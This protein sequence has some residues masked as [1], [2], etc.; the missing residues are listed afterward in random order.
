[1]DGFDRRHRDRLKILGA[2]VIYSL[3]NG[4]FAIKPLL[5]LTR[6]SAR[7]EVE[8]SIQNKDFIKLEIMVKGKEKIHVKGNVIRLSDP[9][10]EDSSYIVVQFL[11][12]GT[13]ERYNSMESYDLLGELIEENLIPA[14]AS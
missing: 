11:P 4:Q 13:D 12:F 2:E 9:V 8:H 6:N 7:F 5:D 3:K 1:M 14:R 10:S